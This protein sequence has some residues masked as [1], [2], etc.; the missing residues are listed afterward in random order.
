MTLSFSKRSLNYIIICL[1]LSTITVVVPWD[2]LNPR[3]YSIDRV[4]YLFSYDFRRYRLD[5]FSADYYYDYVTNEWLWRYLNGY[6]RNVL[7]IPPELFFGMITFLGFFTYSLFVIIKTRKPL[8]VLYLYNPTFILFIYSQLRLAFAMSV[9]LIA[10]YLFKKKTFVISVLLFVLCFLIHTAM[11]IFIFVLGISFY[12]ARSKA[13][14]IRKTLYVFLTGLLINL[15]IGPLRYQILSA[16][17]DRRAEYGDLSSPVIYFLIYVIYFLVAVYINFR[18]KL[19]LFDNYTYVYAFALFSFILC[20][21][22]LGGY[23][24][25][26]VAAGQCFII[27][28]L[29]IIKGKVGVLFHFFYILY[30]IF[31]WVGFLT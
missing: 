9:F 21:L 31:L 26:F 10:L 12:I 13:G 30:I 20:T 4:N 16:I 1:I 15:L 23:T 5:N 24:G 2:S 17:D 7:D 22:F 27:A 8:A 28:S 18:Y 6:A 11:L 3:G 14:N 25:R 19:K 29:F